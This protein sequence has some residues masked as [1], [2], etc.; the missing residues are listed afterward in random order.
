MDLCHLKNSELEPQY[1]KYRGRVVLRGDSV[2][3]DSGSNAVFTEQGSSAS[4]MTAAKV[5]DVISRPPGG[6]G[7]AADT[8]S[9]YTEVKTEDFPKFPNRNVQILRYVYQDANRLNHGP[10]LKI[11]LFLLTDRCTV[12]LEQ[13]CYEKGNSRKFFWK[14]DGRRF[15]IGNACSLTEKKDH[16]CLCTWTISKCQERNKIWIRCGKHS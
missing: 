9:A 12:I 13:D 2:K 11:Q 10:V 8:V 14:T 6:A 7:Q 5:M 16:S 1:Q 3:D 15:P 4:Q